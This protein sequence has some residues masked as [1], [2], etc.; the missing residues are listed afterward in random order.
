MGGGPG[1]V[2]IESF[3]G[4]IVPTACFVSG[5][6]DSS[7]ACALARRAGPVET[8]SLGTVHGD[9]FGPAR[10]WPRG[11][12]APHT[13][14]HL[15]RDRVLELFDRAV[16]QNEVTDGLSAEV[17][18]QLAALHEAAGR[19]GARCERVT[20]GYGSDLLFDGM[21]RVPEYMQAV[22]L[23][24]SRELIERTRWTGELAPFVHWCHGLAVEHVFWSLP[25][26][27]LA[28]SIPRELCS[29]DDVEKAV[30]RRAAVRSGLLPSSLAFKQKVPL[31]V[32][33]RANLL[34]SEALG[35]E[36]PLG[37]V[38]KSRACFERLG[39]ALR[40]NPTP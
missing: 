21:L 3:S 16:I 35:L 25:V 8:F 26:I 5:G 14:V 36:D 19:E 24:S 6:I 31:T 32:G 33:T 39:R 2:L 30:L 22:G 34:L 12:T 9:E 29:S 7:I 20:T 23:C 18:V 28:L 15:T 1:A 4:S 11:S 37:Y 13:E 38:E 27:E 40:W 17:L 10:T